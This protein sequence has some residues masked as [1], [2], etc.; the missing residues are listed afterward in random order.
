MR[1]ASMLGETL[2]A[3]GDDRQHGEAF[4]KVRAAA[5]PRTAACA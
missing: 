2:A 5:P 1:A 3:L 4:G